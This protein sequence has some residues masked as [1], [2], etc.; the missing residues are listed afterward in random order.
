MK[1]A[2]IIVALLILLGMLLGLGNLWHWRS[3]RK[4]ALSLQPGDSKEQVRKALGK[5]VQIFMPSPQARTNFLA[6]LLSVRSETWA[7][8]GSFDISLV[9]HGESPLVFRIFK[10]DDKD[11]S[12]VFDSSG[13]VEE[14]LIPK[15]PP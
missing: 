2:A 8:G 14:V 3:L 7:Y 9:F 1:K 15:N 5:P 13:R 4:R 11:M 12:V 6:A 10:P